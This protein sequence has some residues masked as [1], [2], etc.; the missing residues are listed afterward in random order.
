MHLVQLYLPLRDN[1]GR[2]FSKELLLKVHSELTERFGGVTAFLHS[3]TLGAWKE[4]GSTVRDEVAL[5]EVMLKELHRAWWAS[6]REELERRFA[7]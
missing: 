5:F 4:E 2:P 7:Q 6:Y 1:D 3:P